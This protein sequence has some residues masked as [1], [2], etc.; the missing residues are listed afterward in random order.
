MVHREKESGHAEHAQHGIETRAIH[1]GQHPDPIHGAVAPPIYQSSTFAFETPEQG[2]RRF[3]GTEDGYIYSRLGNPTTRMLEDCVASLEGGAR[4]LAVASG[5]AAVSTI[6]LGLLNQGDHV[7]MTD[8]VYGPT[9]LLLEHD[10]SRFGVEATFVDSS[11]LDR[12]DEALRPGTKMMFIETPTNPTLMVTDLAACA[13]FCRRRGARLVVDNTFASPVLQRPLEHGADIVM[14][15]TTK[16]ING[17]SDVVGGVIVTREEETYERLR[18]ARSSFGGS[19]DPL[20]SWLVLRG[21]KTLPMRVREAQANAQRLAP[22]IG[23][24][25]AVEKVIYP[26]LESHP[27]HEL[28]KRQMDGP[29]SMISFLLAGGY[30]A[31]VAL[32]N[33]VT[34]PTLAVSLGGVESLIEHPASMTH[35]GLS[36][37]ELRETG[38]ASSFVRLAVGCESIDDLLA[39]LRQA[40]DAIPR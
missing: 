23:E 17:H 16:Y 14:H 10:L 15:S 13:E 35:A 11:R 7:V 25:P 26:G 21:V 33:A 19:M 40:L 12:V 18:K 20:Q 9:R 38:I 34:V 32:M 30:E 4:G 31:G 8:T 39:D 5:M 24:H 6:M 28:T 3:A 29:G 27:H 22:M 37:T 1:A 2:A 36:E